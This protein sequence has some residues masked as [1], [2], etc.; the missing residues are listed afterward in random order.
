MEILW[1][2]TFFDIFDITPS[3]WMHN[4]TLLKPLLIVFVRYMPPDLIRIIL[5]Y[6]RFIILFI[7]LFVVVKS[8]LCLLFALLI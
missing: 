3:S 6:H 8:S 4:Q 5:R 1:R 7:L 2:V